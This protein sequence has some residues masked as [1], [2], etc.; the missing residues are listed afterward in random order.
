MNTLGDWSNHAERAWDGAKRFL[1]R[2]G[3]AQTTIDP[4]GYESSITAAAVDASDA[5]LAWVETR[6]KETRRG[7]WDITHTLWVALDGNV[8]GKWDLPTYNPFFGCEIGYLEWFGDSI[9][10]I[11]REK[12]ESIVAVFDTR[13]QLNNRLL[14][15][16]DNWT[17]KGTTIY[18]RSEERGLIESCSLPE[19]TLGVPILSGQS[20]PA[21]RYVPKSDEPEA[22]LRG[23]STAS[24]TAKT[25]RS[26]SLICWWE[27]LPTASG[28]RGPNLF[29]NTAS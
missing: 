3:R 1:D 22:C 27:H 9:A 19:L 24:C 21:L 28:T 13:S 18:F 25:H 7:Y 5:R 6:E 15:I 4:D 23:K 26:R 2:L 8:L 14:P 29:H 17:A 12:H 11:Y 20:E 10:I 16:Q